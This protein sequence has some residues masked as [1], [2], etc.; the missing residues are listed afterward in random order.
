VT[1]SGD[2]RE[3]SAC[4]VCGA[5]QWLDVLSF[6]LMPL[7]NRYVSPDEPPEAEPRFPL[8]VVFCPGCGLLCLKQVVDPR[9]LYLHYVYISSESSTI[10]A[11]TRWLAERITRDIGL[12]AESLVVEFGSNIGSQLEDFLALGNRVLGVDPAKNLAEIAERRGI[13]TIADFFDA[14]SARTVIARAGKPAV[15]L[16]RHVFAHID[17]LDTVFAAADA[18]LAT[19]GVVVIEVPYL[20][21]MV[22]GNEFDTIYHEHLSYFSVGT[23]RKLFG[24]FGFRIFDVERVA[25]HGGSIVVFACPDAAKWRPTARLDAVLAEEARRGVHTAAYFVDFASRARAIRDELRALVA[26][27][28]RRAGRVAGYGAPAKGN[29]LLNFCGLGPAELD[30]VTDTTEFKQGMLLPGTRVPIHA[31]AHGRRHPPDYFLLLAWNYAREIV[32]KERAFLE[33][34]GRFIVPI[35]TP[36]VVSAVDVEAFL[37]G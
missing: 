30:F 6:G 32:R 25:V 9:L 13:P 16:G 5:R 20:V 8:D 18:C 4:R 10:Q 34:G 31:E 28:K 19:D 24:R 37:K 21:D 3:V 15:I 11:H 17:R 1:G 26:D 27:V 22:D 29:T 35:P 2:V 36:V 33:R 23:L 7:A 12:G 14:E